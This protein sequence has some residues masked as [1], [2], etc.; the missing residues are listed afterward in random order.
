MK[1]GKEVNGF[2]GTLGYHLQNGQADCETD[3]DDDDDGVEH[4]SLNN[5]KR[6]RVDRIALFCNRPSPF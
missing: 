5:P 1:F 2:P 3:D 6:K 4:W